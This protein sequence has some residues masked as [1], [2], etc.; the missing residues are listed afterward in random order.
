MRKALQQLSASLLFAI[1]S[2]VILLGA[3]TTALA[4]K[5]L[6]DP[7]TPTLTETSL[8]TSVPPADEATATPSAQG[9]IPTTSIPASPSHTATLSPSTACPAPAGW[10]SY[11]VQLG[12]TLESLATR[13]SISTAELKEKNCLVADELLPDTRL[14]MP[15]YPTA[16][17]IPCGPPANWTLTYVVQSGDNLYRIG[18]KYRVS[19]AQLQQANCLGYSTQIKVGQNLRVPNVP[20][21][22]PVVTRTFT[23]TLTFTPSV[24]PTAT[25][26]P[27][28]TSVIET[29]TPTA[30]FTFTPEPTATPIPTESTASESE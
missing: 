23:P 16:T 15:P 27:S 17:P 18:L 24:T 29:N 13:Y 12:D 3:L 5:R 28:S 26:I 1:L 4:E 10:S 9:L 14:Y 2:F 22:T 8:P 7:S 19:V 25:I 21:S 11:I 20:T 6:N 30:T